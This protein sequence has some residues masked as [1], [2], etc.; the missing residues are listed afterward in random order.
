MIKIITAL[1]FVIEMKMEP[2][3][4]KE[5]TY[6]TANE[7]W[8]ALSPTKSWF[9]NLSNVVYRGQAD[10]NWNLT[11]SLLRN[12]STNQNIKFYGRHCTSDELIY[13]ELQLLN[14]F[15]TYCDNIGIR[16]P[17][18]SINFRK[19]TLNIDYQDKYFRQPQLWPNHELIEL[20]ALAQHHGVP[21]RLLDWTRKPC[22]AIYFAVSSAMANHKNWNAESKIAIWLLNTQS[23]YVRNN[24]NIVKVPGSTS[25]NVSAQS[26]LFT[27]HPHSNARGEQIETTCLEKLLSAA[28]DNP[29]LKL[30]IPVSE[31]LNLYHLCQ[32]SEINAATIY[33]NPDG[34]GRAV[35]D[36]INATIIRDLRLSTL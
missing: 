22:V 13:N 17:N 29:L 4:Y 19:N 3:L 32:V 6:E 1:C 26:G 7:L 24:I 18:D 15:T 8:D 35:Q 31:I 25:N 33:P 2:I 10:S 12:N 9:D 30:V 28:P 16:I 36:Y 5:I 21:T 27:M 34:A 14:V 20:M 11:P 23:H